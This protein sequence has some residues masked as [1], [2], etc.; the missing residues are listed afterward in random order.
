MTDPAG[1]VWTDQP[2]EA[3]LADEPGIADDLGP[4]GDDAPLDMAIGTD[5]D[6]TD[7]DLSPVDPQDQAAA[8]DD[9]PALDADQ[10]ATG[11]TPAH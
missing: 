7:D 1:D 2:D 10:I 8:G 11:E 6:A 9:A 3:P 5:L 4:T